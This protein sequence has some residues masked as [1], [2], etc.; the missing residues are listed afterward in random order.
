M[1]EVVSSNGSIHTLIS[2][3]YSDSFSIG[4]SQTLGK[5]TKMTRRD[6]SHTG[7]DEFLELD[8]ERIGK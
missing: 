4:I 3:L 6:I 2:T 7:L 8:R 1:I 5:K